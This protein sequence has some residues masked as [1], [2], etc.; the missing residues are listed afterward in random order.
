MAELADAGDSKSP[1]EILEGPSPSGRTMDLWWNWKTRTLE[2]RVARAVRVRVPPDPLSAGKRIGIALC[3]RSKVLR[4][5]I[6]LSRLKT[7]E[8]EDVENS[9]T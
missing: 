8:K 6:P 1:G 2:G 7:G 9:E 5:R 3:S 4:V